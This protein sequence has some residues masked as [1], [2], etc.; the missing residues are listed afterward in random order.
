M[1][2]E[3]TVA[4]PQGSYTIGSPGP[5]PRPSVVTWA[6]I[7][8]YV[9]AGLL[10]VTA[11][12]VFT[13]MNA[14]VDGIRQAYANDPSVDATDLDN[15]LSIARSILAVIAVFFLVIAGLYGILAI[16]DL[17]GRNGMRITTWVI[18]GIGV[19]CFGLGTTGRTGG[20]EAQTQIN[21]RTVTVHVDIPS[22]VSTIST[23]ANIL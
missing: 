7:L 3:K 9:V 4:Y 8:L 11:I 6:G 5:T 14:V 17:K 21:G 10:V 15:A 13:E 18:G 1:D 20:S 19:L 23:V 12:T 16:F 2:E 22:G